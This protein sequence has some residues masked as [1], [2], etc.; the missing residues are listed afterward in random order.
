MQKPKESK[1]TALVVSVIFVNTDVNWFRPLSSSDY[2]FLHIFT[3]LLSGVQIHPDLPPV[4][5]YVFSQKE[6]MVDSSQFSSYRLSKLLV[7]ILKRKGNAF[8]VSQ[9]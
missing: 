4:V 6:C 5:G 3:A 7:K 9:N 1:N 2:P 8:C